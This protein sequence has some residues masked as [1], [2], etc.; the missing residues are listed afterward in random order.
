MRLLRNLL[1]LAVLAGG[2]GVWLTLP[3]PLAEADVAGLTGDAAKGE[4]VFWATG[5][6]SCH[7]A[8]GAKDAAQLVLTAGRPSRPRSATSWRRTSARTRSM[9]SATGRC[10]TWPMR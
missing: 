9:A 2:V 7:M 3:K 6:A 4:R 10:W 1:I 5:C 8:P